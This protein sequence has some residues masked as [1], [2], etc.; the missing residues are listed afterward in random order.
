MIL[1]KKLGACHEAGY[2]RRMANGTRLAIVI[3]VLGIV[4]A[5]LAT[6]FRMFAPLEIPRPTSVPVGFISL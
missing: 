4:V 6:K 2:D 1:A 5:L 3:M